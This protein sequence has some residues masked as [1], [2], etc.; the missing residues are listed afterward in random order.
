MQRDSSLPGLPDS[1]HDSS[2]STAVHFCFICDK[3][4]TNGRNLDE[5]RVVV[6]CDLTDQ[7]NP[8]VIVIPSIVGDEYALVHVHAWPAMLPR[9]SAASKRRV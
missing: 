9:R 1:Y 3:P 4:F 6:M 8:R 7:Q 5:S 2:S